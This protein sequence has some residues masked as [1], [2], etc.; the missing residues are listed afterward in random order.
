[1]QNA[2]WTEKPCFFLRSAFRREVRAVARAA[3]DPRV[4]WPARWLLWGLVAY[5]LSPV[6]LIPDFV[7]V[8][9]HLDD[10]IIIPAG[11]ALALR[12]VPPAVLDEC[13]AHCESSAPGA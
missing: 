3:R 4:P 9:G 8:L 12:F 11:L 10:L 7:L 2:E 5:A 6:D 13:R 1:M